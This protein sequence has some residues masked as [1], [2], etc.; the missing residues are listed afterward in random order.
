[1]IECQQSHS[2]DNGTWPGLAPLSLAAVSLA[3]EAQDR[4]SGL[5]G[6]MRKN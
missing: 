4:N 6:E 1:V 5:G 3:R 2:V